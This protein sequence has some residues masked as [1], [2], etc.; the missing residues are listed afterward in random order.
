MPGGGETDVDAERGAERDA[1]VQQRSLVLDKLRYQSLLLQLLHPKVRADFLHGRLCDVSAVD[2]L[3]DTGDI[4]SGMDWLRQVVMPRWR[5][6]KISMDILSREADGCLTRLLHSSDAIFEQRDKDCLNWTY[7][8]WAEMLEVIA[9]S[10]YWLEM[11]PATISVEHLTV[12]A[13]IFEGPMEMEDHLKTSPQRS[14]SLYLGE[15]EPKR[16]HRVAGENSKP[17]M[18]SSPK[19]GAISVRRR[20]GEIETICLSGSSS[21]SVDSDAPLAGVRYPPS[22]YSSGRYQSRAT[23]EVVKPKVFVMN[24]WQS[25]RHYLQNYER[26]FYNKFEGNSQ[27]CTQEL[28]NFLPPELLEFYETVGGHQL[29]YDDMKVELLAWYRTQKI[30]GV[31]HWRE[32][33]RNTIM[34]PG[35]PLKLYG[36]RLKEMG[37]R[38]HPTDNF[39]CVREIRHQ[40]LKTVPQNFARQ[41]QYTED[42]A[43]INGQGKKLSWGALMRLAEREDMRARRE[44]NEA[45]G[46]ISGPRDVWFNREETRQVYQT[47][48]VPP[49]NHALQ[50][51]CFV[52][53]LAS[54]E[55]EFGERQ[56]NTQ[57]LLASFTR[58]NYDD[59][60]KTTGET[61]GGGSGNPTRM[62]RRNPRTF[63]PRLNPQRLQLSP[64]V[65][66]DVCPWC[67]KLG[68]AIDDCWERQGVCVGCGNPDHSWEV[69]PRNR[70]RKPVG[71][72]PICPI[73]KG[74]HFGR[75]CSR[76]LN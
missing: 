17:L 2:P 42:A 69:C 41:V 11:P 58:D 44:R 55:G 54:P 34:N 38:A 15:R 59:N 19:A 60:Q 36:L 63:T 43:L 74:P 10:H 66:P 39:E 56:I 46:I 20:A 72:E 23:R 4:L 14:P 8:K 28:A 65:V 31:R 12:P 35:E 61:R 21:D 48:S 3:V 9:A 25:L 40:F 30:S 76:P 70:R 52:Q 57:P 64:P 45:T 37:Q 50:R 67:G 32:K 47:Q 26:Y 71:F 27:D 53:E 68:H 51:N 7:K 18:Q 1:A 73:C 29:S 22:V 49:G 16:E 6:E 62:I 5:A 13:N 24:G 33:L 75:D